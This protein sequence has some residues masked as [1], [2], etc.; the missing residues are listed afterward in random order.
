MGVR[1][2]RRTVKDVQANC[3]VVRFLSGAGELTRLDGDLLQ[4]F[5]GPVCDTTVSMSEVRFRRSVVTDLIFS[6]VQNFVVF[7]LKTIFS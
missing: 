2:H 6:S 1:H 4:R 5:K 3:H 7:I